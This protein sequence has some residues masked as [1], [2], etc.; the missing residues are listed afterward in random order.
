MPDI[1]TATAAAWY[2]FANELKNT[3]IGYSGEPSKPVGLLVQVKP[4]LLDLKVHAR[5][6][7]VDVIGFERGPLRGHGHRHRSFDGAKM[8]SIKL[9]DC[10]ERC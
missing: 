10:G 1:T 5:W 3:S 4:P 7:Q 2:S 6:N 9:S 8:V